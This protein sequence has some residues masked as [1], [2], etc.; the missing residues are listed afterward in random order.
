MADFQDL[1]GWMPIGFEWGAKGASVDW[2]YLEGIQFT[3]PFFENTLQRAIAEPYRLLFR[4]T[5]PLEVLLER[6][7]SHP[8]MEPDGFVFH[9][10][11]CG[12]TLISQMLAASPRNLSISEG[13][14]IESALSADLRH[15]GVTDEDRVEWLRAVVAAIGQPRPGVSRFFL[16][17]DATH[18]LDLPLIRRAYPGVPWV[19]LYRNPV[20]VMVSQ[21]RHR[22]YWTMPGI[23]PIR[24]LRLTPAS[25]ADQEEYLA[26]L[27]EAI[28]EAALAHGEDPRGM[29]VNYTE[30]PDAVFQR[31]ASHFGCTWDPVELQ[32]M[33]RA[34]SRDAKVPANSFESDSEA[35]QREAGEHLAALCQSKLIPVYERLEAVRK[36]RL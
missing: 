32:A 24:G 1:A 7:E 12:S 6:A 20:E 17:F 14:A 30:L 19:F 18:T 16:K 36:G 23:V 5:T 31:L 27:L 21:A 25:F 10:S 26:D 29:F 13:W 11:R 4:R 33:A 22:A 9:M 28:C 3:D 2:C 34:A 8:G 35:K 15:R